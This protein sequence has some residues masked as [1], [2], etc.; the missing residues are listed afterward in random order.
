[1][2]I[3]AT[4]FNQSVSQDIA[5]T[6]QDKATAHGLFMGAKVTQELDPM[7]LLADAA[8]ELTFSL[9]EGEET[10]LDA[11]KEKVGADEKRRFDPFLEAAR[12]IVREVDEKFDQPLNHLERLFKTRNNAALL[13]LMDALKQSSGQGDEPDPADQFILLVGLKDRLGGE[14]PLA[15][16]IDQALE[17]L[18][19]KRT[20]AVA[21]GLAV[22]LAA[23]DFAEL[24]DTDLRATYRSVV[25]DFAS[26]REAMT[27]LRARFG[28]D[29]LGNGLNFLMTVLGNE[30]ASAGPSVEKSQ[31]KAL[32]GDLAV[33]R[34]LGIAHARCAAVLDRLDKKHGV[35]SRMGSEQLLDSVLAARDNQY[36][37]SL[38]FQRVVQ[39]T[40]TPDTEREVL[41]LQDLLQGLRDLPDLFYESHEARQ[42]VQGALQNALD[43]AVRREEEELGF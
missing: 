35:T 18:A 10:R 39:Q 5:R 6:G 26:P 23:Q 19:E 42:R 12:K 28:D 43:D 30:L 14:H 36:A 17:N 16:T 7:S 41:F 2:S 32:T 40:G 15:G 31:L 13:E 20:F 8:E 1:M 3:H 4:Q 22:D 29:N 11:R 38:D 27:A 21:S 24:E 9:S 33:V 34:V 25:A 37:G